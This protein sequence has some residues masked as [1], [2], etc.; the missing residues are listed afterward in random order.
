MG[1]CAATKTSSVVAA[2]VSVVSPGVG[3]VEFVPVDG[4]AATVAGAWI[5]GG[6]GG[7]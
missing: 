7:T 6:G 4:A 5:A 1:E 3:A 2:D